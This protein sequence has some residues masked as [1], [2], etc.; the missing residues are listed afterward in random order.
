[1]LTVLEMVLRDLMRELEPK[2]PGALPSGSVPTEFLTR[3]E[4]MH[5]NLLSP[6]F[7]SQLAQLLSLYL[8]GFYYLHEMILKVA[9]IPAALFADEGGAVAHYFAKRLPKRP[10][11]SAKC[12]DGAAHGVYLLKE[13]G[14]RTGE[15][16]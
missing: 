11:G 9:E 4:E 15:E 3:L 12:R 1:M 7:R 8:G 6:Q 5:L 10:R 13:F 14:G 16:P 2:G